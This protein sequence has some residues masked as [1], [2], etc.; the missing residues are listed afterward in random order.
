MIIRYV[1]KKSGEPVKRF[2]EFIPL[3][4]QTAEHMEETLKSELKELDIDLMDCHGQSYDNASNMAGKYSGLQARIKNKNPN[5][6]FIPCSAHSLNLVGACAAECCLEAVSFFGFIQNLYNFFSAST[7]RW[8]IITAHL[9]KCGRVLT[10]K[11]LSGTRW[12]ARADATKA[13][14]FSYKAI[15]DDFNEIKVNHGNPSAA[16]YEASQLI[17]V[18][19]TLETA[20]MTVLWDDLRRINLTSKALQQVQIDV[21]TIPI[22]YSSLIEFIGQARNDLIQ[23]L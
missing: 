21:C 6:D 12:S 16:Q 19:D 14:R 8:E 23:C 11:S 4:G 1:L 5:A 17:T 2:L 20:V 10:L 13:L 22:L 15:H 7:L 18:M 9:T 3:H